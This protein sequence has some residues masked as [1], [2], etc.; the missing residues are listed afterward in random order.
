M[1]A[2]MDRMLQVE[3]EQMVAELNR[4]MEQEL[5]KRLDEKLKHVNLEVENRSSLEVTKLIQEQLVALMAG[6][7]QEGPH[8]RIR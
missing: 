2:D 3:R 1:Q 7:Q 8:D 6:M 5:Q 4:N